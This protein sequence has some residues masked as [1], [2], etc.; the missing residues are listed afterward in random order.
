MKT[1]NYILLGFLLCA[2][3]VC[4]S[5]KTA[6]AAV[7]TDGSVTINEEN[8]P[9]DRFRFVAQH[10]DTNHDNLLS[11]SERS[12]MKELKLYH[13]TVTIDPD[14]PAAWEGE[15]HSDKNDP[16]VLEVEWGSREGSDIM[17]VK[18]IEYF[19][20]LRSYCVNDY[21]R[22][23]GSL[24]ENKKLTKLCIGVSNKKTTWHEGVSLELPDCS[25]LERDFPMKQLRT[26][27]LGCIRVT[28]FSLPNATN[29]KQLEICLASFEKVD[30]SANKK[31]E[32]LLIDDVDLGKSVF[33]L[34]KNRKLG[35]LYLN[36]DLENG[37]RVSKDNMIKTLTVTTAKQF[38][39]TEYR[40]LRTLNVIGSFSDWVRFMMIKVNRAWY[41]KKGKKFKTNVKIYPKG[42]CNVSKKTKKY[43]YIRVGIKPGSKPESAWVRESRYSPE[44]GA[45]PGATDNPGWKEW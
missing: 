18:G 19:P 3:L 24:K 42:V 20:E 2:A 45:Y 12:V 33:D 28:L 32:T 39:L 8:F 14:Q 41:N 43:V 16:S 44:N 11:K 27:R 10:Y 23:A 29:L 6:H 5:P 1:S 9:D 7:N 37:M 15:D 17:S 34:R 40:N 30:L 31:L 35:T 26:I 13:Y 4:A 25:V 21:M 22:T 36:T 38:D